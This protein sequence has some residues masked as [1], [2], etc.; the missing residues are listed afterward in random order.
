[1]NQSPDAL[2]ILRLRVQN[3]NAVSSPL[4]WGFPAPTAFTG[5]VHALHRRLQEQGCYEDLRL[6]GAGIVCHDFAPQTAE[7]AGRRH[8]VFALTR[9]PVTKEGDSAAIVEEGRANIELSLI[10]GLYGRYARHAGNDALAEQILEQACAMRLAGGSIFPATHPRHRKPV[11][12]PWPA[13]DWE[14][15][16]KVT[17]ELRR[18]LLPGFALIDRSPLLVERV[19]EMQKTQ[20]DATA[21]DALLQ[22][23]SLTWDC[24]RDP[25]NADKGLWSVRSKSGWLVP[26][27]LGY[28]AIAPVQSSGSVKNTRDATLP[29]CFVESVLGLGQ[30]LGPHRVENLEHLLWFH[31]AEPEAG[32]YRCVQALTPQ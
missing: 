18:H 32:L 12:M 27:P 25:E 17:R 3:A 10:I 8:L 5:F 1:M 21:L 20:P 28:A 2:L 24:Q 23:S 30:W 11:F 4:T 7:P 15:A 9:N 16:R 31:Q 14:G 26:L 19:Q 13:G 6:D 29:F 22:F